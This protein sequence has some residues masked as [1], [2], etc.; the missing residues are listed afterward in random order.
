MM[1][2]VGVTAVIVAAA[3][4]TVVSTNRATITNSQI[5]DTQQNVRLATEVLERDIKLAG[6]NYNPSDPST[7]AVPG[8]STTVGAVTKP[9]G[10]RPQDQNSA[11]ADS[12]ADS[13]SMVVPALN[14]QGWTLAAPAGGTQ[15]APA[16]YNSITLANAA[17]SQMI[18]Q[19]LVIGSTISIGGA[20]SKTVASTTATTIGFGVGNFVDARFPI[21]TPVYLMQCVQ[22]QVISN[23]VTCGSAAP[24]LVRNGVPIVDGVEDLQI[25]YA[26]DGCNTIA[27]NPALP[28]GVVDN[29]DGS[30]VSGQPSF[31]QGDFVSNSTW[32]ITPWTPDKIKL[33]QV[34]IVARQTSADVG[35][36]ERGTVAANSSGPVIIGDHDPST[37]TSYSAPVYQQQRRR[38]L[39]R[40]IQPRNL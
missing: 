12:G 19:G 4:T 38:V 8:C 6:F 40:T 3:L 32:A 27:P 24:C 13:I 28:D 2:A 18:A 25:T 10:M 30:T 15:N 26:C 16:P 11:G 37:D 34:S 35:T 5:A 7:A 33:A 39:T 36:N 1:V 29:Q 20:V 14:S 21:G 31:T 23:P 22:Y 17:I 9:A